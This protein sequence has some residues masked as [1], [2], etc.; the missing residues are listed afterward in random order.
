MRFGNAIK[1]AQMTFCLVP[2][3]LNSIYMVMIFSKMRTVIDA[4]MTKFADIKHIITTVSVNVNNA[5]GL[6]FSR[7]IGN[8]VA[9]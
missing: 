3:I 5:L 4:E 1:L 8:S 2:K 6:T 9:D 7:I